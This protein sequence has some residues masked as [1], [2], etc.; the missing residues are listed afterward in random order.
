MLFE[1][2]DVWVNATLLALIGSG[3]V[4]VVS[5]NASR[6]LAYLDEAFDRIAGRRNGQ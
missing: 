4:I 6:A 1:I 2:S 3:W 5:W